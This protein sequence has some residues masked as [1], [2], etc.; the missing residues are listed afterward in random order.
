MPKNTSIL[1]KANVERL[2]KRTGALRISNSAVEEMTDF[3]IKQGFEISKRA[4]EITKHSGRR[5]VLAKDIKLA[6]KF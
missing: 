6:F 2:M 5:T 3:L 1:P 4:V